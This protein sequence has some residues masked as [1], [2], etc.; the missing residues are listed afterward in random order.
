L[1]GCGFVIGLDFGKYRSG[2]GDTQ[3]KNRHHLASFGSMNVAGPSIEIPWR[4]SRSRRRLK[5]ISSTSL[6]SGDSAY[7]R[8]KSH[9]NIAISISVNVTFNVSATSRSELFASA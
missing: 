3:F 1:T 8:S 4:A 2:D 7:P 9:K 5:T 6:S